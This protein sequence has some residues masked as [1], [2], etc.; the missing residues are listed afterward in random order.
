MRI[1]EPR[2]LQQ[3]RQKSPSSKKYGLILLIA[4]AGGVI[5]WQ[6]LRMRAK[7]PAYSSNTLSSHQEVAPAVTPQAQTEP[8][9]LKT[10]TAEEFRN[11]YNTF[12]Y[13]NTIELTSPPP[14]SGNT[15]ADERIQ[16]IAFGRGY[17]L[18]SA[19]VA[20]LTKTAEGFPL[21]EKAIRPWHDMKVAAAK[22]G[23]GLGLVSA[24][25]SVEEQRLIF[26]Q[27]LNATGYTVEEIAAGKADNAVM[28][29]L[30]TTSVPGTSRH[31]TGYTIDL[32][33]DNEDFKQFAATRC[34]EWLSKN[35]YENAKKFGWIPSY[36]SG[37][38]EQGPEPEAWEYVWVGLDTVREK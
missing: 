25:R 29:V 8:M 10:F 38:S 37:T 1:I 7:S 6:L 28:S 9:R 15:T 27:R 5:T 22:E 20:P 12:A 11:L 21:Q 17:R 23:V 30:S 2:Q 26:M 14:I 32:K 19:P 16:S 36:P 4:L 24:F 31:H 35:N 33:C 34:F 3:H 13:P 18:R